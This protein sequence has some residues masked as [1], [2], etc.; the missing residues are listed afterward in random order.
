M[1]IKRGIIQAFDPVTYT[2]SVLLFE[3]TSFFLTGVPVSNVFDGTSALVGSLCAVLFFDEQNPQDAVVIAAFANGSSGLPAPAP[4]RVTFVAG[5][6][7]FNAV[8]IN[9]GNTQTFGVTGG[10]S[11]VPSGASGVL[12]KAYFTSPTVGAYITIT[13]HNPADP[14]AYATLGN[15]AVANGYINGGGLLQVDSSGQ[16]DIKANGGN[17][18]VTLYTHGYV[19]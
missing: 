13:P 3:A 19:M 15:L 12:Y 2:A 8:V 7:Q 6:R 4:G 18:T 9:S 17:C 10:A 16:I 14:N 11:G 1:N 5:Y